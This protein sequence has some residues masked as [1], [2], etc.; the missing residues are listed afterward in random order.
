MVYNAKIARRRAT[1]DLVLHLNSNDEWNK[2][3]KKVLELHERDEE[4]LKYA[5]KEHSKTEENSCILSVLNT[6]EFIAV[7]I[8]EGAFDENTY[9]RLR[10]KAFIRDW[11]ALETFVKEFRR[12][13]NI[14][15][16]FTEF[17]CL[18]TRWKTHWVIR[19]WRRIVGR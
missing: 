13:R 6:N 10:R 11:D 5:L 1:V 16:L 8:I 7:G 2:A 18:A 14:K 19:A 15:E 17:Q 4:F 3:R 12:A 9:K